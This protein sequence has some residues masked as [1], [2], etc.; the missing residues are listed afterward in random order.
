MRLDELY[1]HYGTWTKM[2][3]SLDLGNSTYQLWRKKGF[4][5]FK[6]QLLIEHKTKGR[7]KAKES[8]AIPVIN[9]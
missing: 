1:R 2:I 9:H 8:H 6:T 7:F 5:P 4:I 3:R